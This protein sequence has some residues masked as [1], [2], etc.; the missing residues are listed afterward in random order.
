[1][2]YLGPLKIEFVLMSMHVKGVVVGG[3]ALTPLSVLRAKLC[4]YCAVWQ[5][6]QVIGFEKLEKAVTLFWCFAE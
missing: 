4:V 6:C 3:D 5:C 1:M 2:D